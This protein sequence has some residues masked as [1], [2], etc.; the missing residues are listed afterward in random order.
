MKKAIAIIFIMGLVASAMAFDFTTAQL[1]YD[2]KGKPENV[3]MEYNGMQAVIFDVP[4]TK[5][6]VKDEDV[7][8][9]TMGEG[10]PKKNPSGLPGNPVMWLSTSV[11]WTMDKP[12]SVTVT[13]PKIT[14]LDFDKSFTCYYLTEG[15]WQETTFTPR[16]EAKN[17]TVSF[18]M[19]Y[20]GTYAITYK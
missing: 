14:D 6:K 5:A 17:R 18:W 19:K 1:N 9:F 12:L 8:I 2:A 4:Q 3:I 7:L 20:L 15:N 11:D 16:V 13:F 10:A